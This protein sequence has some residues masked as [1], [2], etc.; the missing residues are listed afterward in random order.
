MCTMYDESHPRLA[1]L[2]SR[3]QRPESA[4]LQSGSVPD[5]GYDCETVR[6]GIP[7]PHIP[8]QLV[9]SFV[10]RLHFSWK[11]YRR[12]ESSRQSR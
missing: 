2:K 12:S 11:S 8:R 5:E 4:P 7:D 6:D 3:A 1:V 9:H 10:Q